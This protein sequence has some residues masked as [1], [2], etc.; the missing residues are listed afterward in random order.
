[1]NG[2]WQTLR[3]AIVRQLYGK[4]FRQAVVKI[5]PLNAAL[6]QQSAT[7][8]ALRRTGD[9]ATIDHHVR[10]HRVR[11]AIVAAATEGDSHGIGSAAGVT[12][13]GYD[14][15]FTIASKASHKAR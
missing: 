8:S 2:F 12:A 14:G 6:L 13:P 3:L 10:A 4:S 7:R 11:K 5:D 9:L 1:M 15:A